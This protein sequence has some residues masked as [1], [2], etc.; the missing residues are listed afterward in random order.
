MQF[1][2]TVL[3][4][5]SYVGLSSMNLSRKKTIQMYKGSGNTSMFD[6]DFTAPLKNSFLIIDQILCRP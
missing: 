1:F 5:E 3:K 4:S 6:F 2:E